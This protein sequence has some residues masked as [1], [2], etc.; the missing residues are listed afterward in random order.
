MGKIVGG[1]AVG[2]MAAVFV[3]ELMKE[4]SK[5]GKPLPPR[6]SPKAQTAAKTGREANTAA[7]LT[8]QETG[9]A[10]ERVPA[11]QKEVFEPAPAQAGVGR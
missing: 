7:P 6:P 1:F 3:K 2:D 4:I 11:E 5:P 10:F 9:K 8:L